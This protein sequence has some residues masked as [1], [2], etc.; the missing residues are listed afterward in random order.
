MFQ[1]LYVILVSWEGFYDITYKYI[2][3]HE[4]GNIARFA[5]HSYELNCR[6]EPWVVNGYACLVLVVDRDISEEE[7]L[8]F[9][10]DSK[11]KFKDICRYSSV[12]C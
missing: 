10:Y 8:T 11:P 12:K 5:N 6:I 7:E 4:I 9:Y 2:N 1:Y 3:A